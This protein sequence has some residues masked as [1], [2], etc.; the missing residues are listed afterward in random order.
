[1]EPLTVPRLLAPENMG[2]VIESLG[3]MVETMLWQVPSAFPA[4]T[5]EEKFAVIDAVMQNQN[6]NRFSFV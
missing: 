5:S 2:K 4:K 1:M 3:A 6:H